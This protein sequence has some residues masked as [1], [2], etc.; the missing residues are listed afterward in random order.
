MKTRRGDGLLRMKP[1]YDEANERREEWLDRE[2]VAAICPMCAVKM[3][4]NGITRI[5]ASV[6][7]EAEMATRVSSVSKVK[8]AL[9]TRDLVS[10]LGRAISR[11]IGMPPI[12]E[13]VWGSDDVEYLTIGGLTIVFKFVVTPN[14]MGGTDVRLDWES[15]WSGGDR[16]GKG[17]IPIIDG[18]R[19]Y[20]GWMM[21]AVAAMK[22]QMRSMEAGS[23]GRI[24]RE[25]VAV[26]RELAVAE[27]ARK[28][29]RWE[30]MPV[31]WTEDSRRQFWN[32][33]T[34]GSVPDRVQE[35]ID[36]L[37]GTDIT[38]PGAFCA[39]L[40]DRIT[41]RTDWRGKR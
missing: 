35:C 7:R 1:D 39:A 19:Q 13:I 36:K 40:A 34:S 41:G 15:Y 17:S 11:S 25:L 10:K 26:A 6:V 31:G 22:A 8:L 20:R 37:A 21:T 5:K 9:S 27:K 18:P 4:D 24:V 14:Q 33:L 29:D 16:K 32:S 28:A 30:T 2:Q 38:D 3:K 12:K 23:P